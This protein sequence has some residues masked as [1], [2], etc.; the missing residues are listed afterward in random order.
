MFAGYAIQVQKNQI[1]FSD[2]HRSYD[3]LAYPLFFPYGT[4][5]WNCYMKS[6]NLE[7][8]TNVSLSQYVRFHMM[9]RDHHKFFMTEENCINNGLLINMQT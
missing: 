7:N 3:P 4:D 9:E 1:F 5:E 6:L 8:K 2:T